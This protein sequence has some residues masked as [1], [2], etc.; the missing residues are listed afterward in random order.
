MLSSFISVLINC[1]DWCSAWSSQG[2]P[3]VECQKKAL[4]LTKVCDTHTC[5]ESC[6][7]PSGMHGM[8]CIIRPR[9]FQVS[10]LILAEDANL[11]RK[12][13]KGWSLDVHMVVVFRV[14]IM[15]DT[16]ASSILPKGIDVVKEW[17]G[18]AWKVGI[19]GNA[20]QRS[21]HPHCETRLCC[22]DENGGKL[23]GSIPRVCVVDD[24]NLTSV[25]ANS[26]PTN[27]ELDP[28]H[29]SEQAH[30]HSH[31]SRWAAALPP[32]ATHE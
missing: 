16:S 29:L 7:S 8:N 32:T 27:D 22:G 30:A 13:R 21:T 4:V 3:Q 18:Q 31:R 25:I 23:E 28:K 17:K 9:W 2:L 24:S 11:N 15:G 10:V 5:F 1:E 19:Y 14:Y 6:E 20:Q 12:P 26:D